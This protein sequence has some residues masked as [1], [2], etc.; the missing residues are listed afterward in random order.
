VSDPRGARALELT[1]DLYAENLKDYLSAANSYARVS[2]L[3]TAD[4]KAPELLIKA[5]N[6]CADKLKDY[7]KAIEYYQMVPNLY[8]A[9]KKVKEANKLTDKASKKLTDNL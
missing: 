3:Y 8:P 9:S 5:G 6:V 7:R 4:E 2:K 1:G